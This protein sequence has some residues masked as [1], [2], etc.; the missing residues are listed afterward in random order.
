MDLDHAVAAHAQ[1][2]AKFRAA[3]TAK[4]QMDTATIGRDN[5]CDLGKWLHGEGK[6]QL[7]AKPEFSALIEKHRGFHTEAGKVATLINAKK[8]VEA[9]A[10][11]AGSTPFGI[12]SSETA[13]AISRLKNTMG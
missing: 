12:A 2:K 7:G 4:Q 11:I 1:W 13:V 5:C 9:E 8:Y 3:I 6:M 10:A